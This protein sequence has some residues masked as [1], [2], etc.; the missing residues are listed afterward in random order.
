MAG[1]G[2]CEHECVNVVGSFYC[3]CYSGFELAENGVNCIGIIFYL[4]SFNLSQMLMNAKYLMEAVN[5]NV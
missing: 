3:R 5:L 2:G 1:N 4:I